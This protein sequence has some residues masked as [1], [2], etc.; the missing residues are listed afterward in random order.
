MRKWYSL[1]D[2]VYSIPMLERSYFQVK[3]NKG[4]Q[5]AGVDGTTMLSYEQNLDSNLHQLQ[6]KLK[7][8]TFK[9][10]PVRRAYISKEDGSKRGLGI[11]TIE[12]RIVQQALHNVLQP[13]FE[14]DFHPS[15]YGY[16]PRRSAHHAVAKAE[17]FT[18]KYNLKHVVDMDM[19]KFFDTLDHDLLIGE[20]NRR[21]SDGKVL[22]LIRNFLESGVMDKGQMYST[23]KGSP[24]GGI[25]SPLLANIYLDRFDQ[26]MKVAG[27]RIVRYADDILIFAETRTKAGQYQAK[28]TK[29]L[30][31]ELK[32]TVNKK[33][34]HLTNLHEGINYLGFIIVEYGVRVSPKSIKK[35]KEKVRLL[36]PRTKGKS[37][38]YYINELNMLLRG[39]SNYY[40]V[41]LTKSVFIHLMSW[42]RRR[43]RMMIMR[44]WKSWKPLHK[45]LRKMGYQG[46]FKKI[47]V[48]RWRNS[49]STL[50]HMALSKEYFDSVKL[51]NMGKVDS[52]VLHQYYSVVISN[53][54]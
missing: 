54:I 10:Q 21:V 31:Q 41:A 4:S 8:G 39:W 43:L 29:Y 17:Q 53:K 45:Q 14:P 33:K 34:T 36:S 27:I 28:A 49:N 48:T 12:D 11:P 16:R 50:I 30:E 46:G 24:Q 25:I 20:I 6:E 44:A 40:K 32:L 47:S 35:F 3:G 42:I 2:K 37:I 15:S 22:E 9:A 1:I 26:Y 51:Y 7:T 23:E 18:R 5:T 19:S 38:H 13:I 52:N